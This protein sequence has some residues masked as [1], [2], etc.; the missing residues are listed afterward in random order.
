MLHPSLY[1]LIQ[2]TPLIQFSVVLTGFAVH[3]SSCIHV[4][5]ETVQNRIEG[6]DVNGFIKWRMQHAFGVEG[7]VLVFYTIW[8]G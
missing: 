4:D 2:I 5:G 1:K 7:D 8:K 3:V 6:G